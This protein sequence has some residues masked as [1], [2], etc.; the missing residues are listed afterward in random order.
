MTILCKMID[1]CWTTGYR[2]LT[3]SDRSSAHCISNLYSGWTVK[4]AWPVL[5]NLHEDRRKR[6]TCPRNYRKCQ[7]CYSHNSSPLH[8]FDWHEVWRSIAWQFWAWIN[9]SRV[10]HLQVTI[11]SARSTFKFYRRIRKRIMQLRRHVNVM[12]V[13]MSHLQM[14]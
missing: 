1:S 7:T 11:K 4:W 12:H 13:K 9:K 14:P 5:K 3:R 10:C 8:G 6:P 2:L